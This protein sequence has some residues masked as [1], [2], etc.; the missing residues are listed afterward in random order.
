MLEVRKWRSEAVLGFLST[1]RDTEGTWRSEVEPQV[2]QV[3]SPPRLF[4]IELGAQ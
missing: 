4:T 3:D 1:P 2:Q